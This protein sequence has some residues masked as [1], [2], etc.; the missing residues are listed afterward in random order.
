MPLLVS[1]AEWAHPETNGTY[2]ET[3]DSRKW[4]FYAS[5]PFLL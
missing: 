1:S 2:F 4:Q 3:R 5:C